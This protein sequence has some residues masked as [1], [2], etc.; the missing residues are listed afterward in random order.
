[1]NKLTGV[2]YH[3]LKGSP[4]WSK[5]D[6]SSIDVARV[7]AIDYKKRA[8]KIFDRDKPY[9]LNIN[10]YLVGLRVGVAP[11]FGS[12]TSVTVYN[13]PYYETDYSKKI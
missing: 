7:L 13:E 5:L 11:S 10:Y 3:S 2:V 6:L 1:M 9:T 4:G 12:H 8:F